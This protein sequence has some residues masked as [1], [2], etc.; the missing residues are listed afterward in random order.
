MVVY[1]GFYSNVSPIVPHNFDVGKQ[2]RL[3]LNIY[4]NYKCCI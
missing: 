2:K 3:N 1:G 4:D